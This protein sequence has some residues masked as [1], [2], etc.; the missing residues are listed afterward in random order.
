MKS[1]TVLFLALS[2]LVFGQVPKGQDLIMPGPQNSPVPGVIDGVVVK[3]EVPVRS[4]VEYEHVRLADY[5]WSKRIFSRIDAREKVNHPLFFPYETF[6]RQFSQNPP[7]TPA[8]MMSHKGWIRNQERLSLWTIIQQNLMAGNLS[9]YTVCDSLDY[10]YAQEDGYALKYRINKYNDNKDKMSYYSSDPFYRREMVQGYENGQQRIGIFKPGSEWKGLF[11]GQDYEYTTDFKNSPTFQSWCD[12]IAKQDYDALSLGPAWVADVLVQKNDPDFEKAWNKAMLKA[13]A[14][15]KDEPLMTE[16][17]TFYLSSDLI[18]A[19][20]IKEDWFFDKERS[21]LDKRII[22]IAPV[23]R[24]M[25]S[26]QKVSKRGGL[27]AK[28]DKGKFIYVLDGKPV[29]LRTDVEL[30]TAIL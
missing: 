20:N 17:I 19:Y 29:P 2:G 18:T 3:D 23:A 16:D 1:V 8:E 27:I 30:K 12:E 7:K 14:S 6:T 24:H 21:M 28:D 13:K 26:D 10:A 22:A 15:G 11:K 25:I 9:M 4:I 5:V